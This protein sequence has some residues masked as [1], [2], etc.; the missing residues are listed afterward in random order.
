MQKSKIS[1]IF[2]IF[3]ILIYLLS[4]QFHFSNYG[5]VYTFI[6]NPLFFIIIALLVKFFIP[7][8]YTTKKFKKDII[9]YVLISILLY[10][11]LYLLSGLLTGFGSNPYSTTFRGI[12]INLYATGSIIFCREYIRYKLINNVFNKD[13]KLIFVLLVL[14]FSLSSLKVNTLLSSVNIY[15][16]F[17]QIFYTFVPSLIKNILFTYL[18]IYTDYIPGFIYEILYYILIWTS[19]ILPNSPWVLE[20]IIN[21]IFPIILLLF[22]RYHIQQK[23]R[24]HLNSISKPVNP[25]GILPLTIGLVLVIWFALGIFPIKPV[26]IATGSMVPNL[27]IGDL[28]IIK[29]CTP[30]DINEQD[31]IE[32]Q[33]DGYTVI[34]RVVNISQ[35]NGEFI[36][37][38]KG[39]NNTSA[40][41]NAVREDQLIGKVLFKIRYLA[42]PTILIHNLNS[43]V[44]VDVETGN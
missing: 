32:Y 18:V 1:T 8:P 9:Q 38:T 12:I 33:M 28:V 14:V 24:F 4:A 22:C 17:K 10:A 20:A 13:K 2:I 11:L 44:Q 19:P 6:I 34:H 5:N 35:N 7:P 30:N 39:D 36:F 41:K 26:G 29:K 3:I 43:K 21:S 15:Y 42:I 37:T 27:N 25:S 40:D 31:I 23:D 16:F